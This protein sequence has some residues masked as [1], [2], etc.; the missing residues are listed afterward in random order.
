MKIFIN[1]ATL[2]FSEEATLSNSITVSYSGIDDLVHH[3]LKEGNSEAKHYHV[4]TQHPDRVMEE[5][6]SAYRLI[7]AAGGLVYNNSGQLL[8]IKRLGKWDLPK[9]KVEKGEKVK[10]AA[11]REV[12][13]E[14]G[15]E[16]I[17]I[18]G[19]P[20]FTYHMY[21]HKGKIVLKETYW[22]PMSS[23]YTGKLI[24]QEEEGITE[25]CWVSP[26][27]FRAPNI[28]TYASLRSL[29]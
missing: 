7:R 24:P 15:I 10:E 5:H 26:D 27:F 12:Q 20:L 22:Y 13:E 23:L 19:S 8:A 21:R 16:Q 14:C 28:D 1:A 18:S 29:F 11:L 4:P 9:G 17:E 3:C 25:V 2:E 6:L